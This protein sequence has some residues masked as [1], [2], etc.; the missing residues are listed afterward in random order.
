M[1]SQSKNNKFSKK[2]V[3]EF[4]GQ[5]LGWYDKHQRVLPWRAKKGTAAD[6]YHVWLSEIML[7]QTTVGA[8]GPYFVKFLERWPDVHALAACPQ[9]DLMSAWAGLGY[10]ARA[11]N[12]HKCAKV[13]SEELGG[14]FPQESEALKKLPGIGEYTSAAIAAIAFNK[15]ATVVDGNVERVMARIFAIKKPLPK[16][17]PDLKQAA[18]QFFDGFDARPGDLAQA[19]MDLGATICI[20]KAPRCSLCP[21]SGLC[22]GYAQ[23]IAATLPRKEKKTP[24]PQKHGHV[25]WITNDNQEVLLHRR[26]EKGMLGGMLG[27]PTSE[28]VER[29]EKISALEFVK[30]TPQ[31]VSIHHSFTHFDLELKLA[32]A[33]ADDIP[34]SEEYFWEKIANV[35]AN[36]FP[37]LFKKALK[38]FMPPSQ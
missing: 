14:E 20:P 4:R 9:E 24:N 5:L 25:Y 12:L 34:H 33:Q 21:V 2:D 11:R 17:K 26:P 6:P 23:G 30:H 19:F 7:Q 38:L 28:W 8:V 37:T 3:Q 16:S 15:P 18:A 13:V 10:Y 35:R 36:D 22:A 32:N 29:K 1:A 31:K 27:L